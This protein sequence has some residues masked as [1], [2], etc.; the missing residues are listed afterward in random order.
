MGSFTKS[1]R[2]FSVAAGM[3]TSLEIL[4]SSVFR[5]FSSFEGFIG[6]GNLEIWLRFD[7]PD[8]ASILCDGPVTGELSR[9]CD[10]FDAHLCP[11]LWI[12]KEKK[13]LN[14]ATFDMF[15][16]PTADFKYLRWSLVRIPFV[17][18]ALGSNTSVDK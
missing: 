5:S 2:A 8:L 6:S 15:R 4:V 12:L 7:A 16:A 9:R 17:C 14:S 11:L 3:R 1:P 13:Y 18:I 10:V